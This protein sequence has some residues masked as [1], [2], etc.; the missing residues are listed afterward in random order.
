VYEKTVA[1]DRVPTL[2]GHKLSAED[3]T[4]REQILNFMTRGKVELASKE[5][6]EDVALFLHDMIEDGLVSLHDK[7]LALTAAGRPFLR[8]ACV[9]L[10]QR[11]R[12][13]K[14]A[15]KVF[16]KAL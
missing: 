5:Q 1:E 15:T 8:N 13:Q 16:S 6:A 10:D 2:R 4:Q 12:Q 9:A 3:R 11:L 7:T 14:P